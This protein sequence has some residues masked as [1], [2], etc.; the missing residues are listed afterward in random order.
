MTIQQGNFLENNGIRTHYHDEGSGIPLVLLHGSGPGV[1][2][3]ENWGNV[4]PHLAENYRVIAAD[5]AGFGLTD[6]EPDLTLNMKVWVSQL[7]G[8]LE[9]LNV[10]PS[11]LVGNSFGGALSLA[12]TLRQPEAVLGLVLM[13]TPAGQFEQTSALSEGA[14]FEPSLEGM[15]AILERFP[16]DTSIVTESMVRERYEMSLRHSGRTALRA[17]MPQ[18]SEEGPRLVRGMPAE[19]LATIDKPAL[20]LHGREDSVIPMEV[21]VGAA[22]NLPKSELHIFGECGHWVQLERPKAFVGLISEFLSRHGF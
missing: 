21:A 15:R 3:W 4:I 8:F 11:V 14:A 10:G 13:G 1:S 9:A 22:R 5:M 12:A 7:L 2:A 16:Y 19:K 20:L 6:C 17:L 18:S